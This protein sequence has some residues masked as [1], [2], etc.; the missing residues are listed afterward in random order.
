MFVA[1]LTLEIFFNLS[2]VPNQG[3]RARVACL[4]VISRQ[5]RHALAPFGFASA[6]A[7]L[8]AQAVSLRSSFSAAVDESLQ[9]DVSISLESPDQKTRGFVIQIALPR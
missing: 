1:S 8:S 9:E 3:Y 2:V 6:L 5:R 7:A 4:I